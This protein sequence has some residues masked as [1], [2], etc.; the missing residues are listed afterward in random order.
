MASDVIDAEKD[1]SRGLDV[2]RGTQLQGDS[3]LMRCVCD[4]PAVHNVVYD[5]CL[6]L[7]GYGHS[8]LHNQAAA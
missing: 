8:R 1:R 5:E 2:A 3:T 4:D 7:A 6:Q